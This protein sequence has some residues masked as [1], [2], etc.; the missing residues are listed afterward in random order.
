MMLTV[1]DIQRR[2]P[3]SGTRFDQIIVLTVLVLV[4]V[5]CWVVMRPFLSAICWAA[6]LS[7]SLSPIYEWLCRMVGGKR[8]LAAFILT[9]LI[10]GLLLLPAMLIFL[11]LGENVR[12]FVTATTAWLKDGPPQPPEWVNGLPV[13]G[14]SVD[15]YWKELAA[16]NARFARES[17]A[18]IEPATDSLIKGSLL[19]GRGVIELVLSVFIAFF[20]LRQ[21]KELSAWA[22]M[23]ADRLAGDRGKYL[24]EDV[25][26][27]TVR[28]VV[29]GLLGTA[30]IQGL[31]AGIGF[32]VAGVPAALLLGLLTFLLSAVPFGPPLIWIP[33]V[34]WSL[35][36]QSVGTAIFLLILGTVVS[37]VDNVVRP[38]FISQE[39]KVPFLLVFFGV[40]GGII[41]FGLI[42]LFL[43]PTLLVVGY[44]LSVEWAR[45]S[46]A[47]VP[48]VKTSTA[49]VM[50][51]SVPQPKA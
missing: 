44:R 46:A 15:A 2:K 25:A 16:D 30:L 32:A 24:L 51:I 33:A 29:Y 28:G 38:F 3:M 14:P 40:L 43:G 11:G 7:Y 42:G 45:T 48:E 17:G 21:G 50:G 9:F 41:A 34:I 35:Q 49:P 1:K 31:L 6:I 27:S 19:L 18:L 13:V 37:T 8:T 20:F 22:R 5:G 23:I 12:E 47:E 4:V 10:A 36:H 39:S 26:G